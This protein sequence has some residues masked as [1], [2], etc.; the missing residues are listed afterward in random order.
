[1]LLS[2]SWLY[3]SVKTVPFPYCWKNY[4]FHC[5]LPVTVV[6]YPFK[7]FSYHCYYFYQQFCLLGLLLIYYPF[8]Q[9][10]P[11]SRRFEHLQRVPLSKFLTVRSLDQKHQHYRELLEMQ[12]SSN[13]CVV[14]SPGWFWRPNFQNIWLKELLWWLRE[15]QRNFKREETPKG[16]FNLPV[17]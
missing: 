3:A 1:M 14:A 12:I 17:W 10:D 8:L 5:Y 7:N 16:I 4:H 13:L 15:E 2:T 9:F 6:K 11:K